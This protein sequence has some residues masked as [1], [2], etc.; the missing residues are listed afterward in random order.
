MSVSPEAL[1]GLMMSI[2]ETGLLQPIGVVPSGK[3]DSYEIAYGNRRFLAFSRLGYTS[4][5]AIVHEK[6]SE[7]DVD[8]KNLTENIQ[9]RNLTLSE[10]GRYIE[11]LQAQGLSQA[12]VAV[13]LGVSKGYIDACLRSFK[14]VPVEFRGDLEVQHGHGTSKVTPGKISI[15]AAR[16]II[17]AEKSYNL[18]PQQIKTL[19][20]AAKTDERFT[21]ENVLKYAAAIKKGVK[22]PIGSVQ[23]VKQIRVNFLIT[24]RHYDEMFR[25]YINEGPFQSMSGLC[26]AIL[27]GEKNQKI[28]VID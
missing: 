22:D 11:L 26:K 1:D 24:E 13:R 3:G 10:A 17:N 18:K 23:P 28:N 27:K 25:K 2:K 19:F 6:K 15:S 5:P 7:S 21:T 8:M 9:R 16:S 14:D 4:I 12:E 20:T